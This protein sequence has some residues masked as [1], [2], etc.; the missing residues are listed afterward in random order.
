MKN[1][2]SLAFSV[3]FLQWIPLIVTPLQFTPHPRVK[4]VNL[5][6]FKGSKKYKSTDEYLS[7]Q[8]QEC[9]TTTLET[10]LDIFC[11]RSISLLNATNAAI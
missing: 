10:T 11:E 5:G 6:G 7:F 4:W 1:S 2:K 8:I 3:L 9:E